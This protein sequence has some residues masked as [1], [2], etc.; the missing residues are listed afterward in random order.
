VGLV[1]H[2]GVRRRGSALALA[3]AA[4]LGCDSGSGRMGIQPPGVTQPNPLAVAPVDA[5]PPPRS[6]VP[7]P[8]DAGASDG[9]APGTGPTD[10]PD[11]GALE[12]GV[13]GYVDPLSAPARAT[14][15]PT[16]LLGA[17]VCGG[18]H[19][20]Q[21]AEWQQA[22]HAR[23]MQDPVFQALVLKQRGELGTQN[24]RLCTGCHSPWGNRTLAIQPGFDFA[25]LPSFVQEGV[26]C[27]TCHRS[28]AVERPYNAGL[29]LA[30]DGILRGPLMDPQAPH[31]AT[32][33]PVF[34][35]AQ[36]CGAC[37]DVRMQNGVVLESPYAEWTT[38]PAAAAGQTCQS[39][40]MPT[41]SG[42]AC[43]LPGAPVRNNLHSHRFIGAAP[44][45]VPDII[46]NLEL[47]TSLAADSQTLLQESASVDLHAE[48][49]ANGSVDI[50]V[51]TSNL[52]AGHDFP[53][54]SDFNRQAWIAL[55]VTDA[56]GD[57]VLQSGQL[58]GFGDLYDGFMP[59]NAGT[60]VDPNLWTFGTDLRT[61]DGALTRYPWQAARTVRRSIP[62]LQTQERHYNL[63]ER[64]LLY[65]LH[66][67][68]RFK[69]RAFAPAL[70]RELGLDPLLDHVRVVDIAGAEIEI[71]A[72]PTP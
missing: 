61:A 23:A 51:V 16:A 25:A 60:T 29:V 55:D 4:A 67:V 20:Q 72:P 43:N 21:Y 10:G 33:A 17:Q 14:A 12:P 48:A 39:C 15:S 47:E 37:H 9:A 22:P 45:L 5:G 7:V 19:T 24:D 11:G 42:T 26:S 3:C 36:L 18:C 66:A 8:P 52:I 64:E 2:K 34:D 53:T 49:S 44:P 65:P 69:F 32:F 31:A 62:A 59:A 46:N 13:S 28:E 56:Q 63:G 35:Q 58:D 57:R 1:N 70:L 40:H 41:Y 6:P 50:V 68:V 27:E 54:G 38:S 30:K 71:P